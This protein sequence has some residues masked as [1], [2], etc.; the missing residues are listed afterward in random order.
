MISFRYHIVSLVAVFLALGLGILVGTTV[1]N[2]ATVGVLRR[3]VRALDGNL[4]EARRDI[5]ELRAER[6]QSRQ[7]LD[8]LSPRALAGRLAQRPVVLV[9]DG[10][11][12]RWR[13][14]VRDGLQAAGAQIA[15]TIALTDRWK[16]EGSGGDELARIV[17]ET[18]GSFEPGPAP[19]ETALTVAGRRA[20]DDGGQSLIRRLRDAGFLESHATEVRESFPPPGSLFVAF[21]SDFPRTAGQPRWLGAFAKGLGE[22]AGTLV[23]TSSPDDYSGVTILREADVNQ[24]KLATFDSGAATHGRATAVLSL[25][26]AAAARG[27]HF[28]TE[29]GR[30]VAPEPSG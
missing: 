5:T 16:L 18:L 2:T 9:Y 30:R 27:G 14:V 19:A 4:D 28:G 25:E 29:R 23:V 15:G 26:A 6:D 12:G 3:Q 13:D 21:A 10:P 20:L 17:Q 24:P 11:T 22:V 8:D 7:L 1:I